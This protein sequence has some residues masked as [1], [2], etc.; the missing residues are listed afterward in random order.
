VGKVHGWVVAM[1]G[2]IYCHQEYIL[3]KMIGTA[4][5]MIDLRGNATFALANPIANAKLKHRL[6]IPHRSISIQ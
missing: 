2:A 5:G 3:Q 6:P 1:R 4:E